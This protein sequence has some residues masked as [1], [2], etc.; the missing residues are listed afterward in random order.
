MTA[1]PALLRNLDAN[2]GTLLDASRAGSLPV[3]RARL[4]P[5]FRGFLRQAAKGKAPAALT[6]SYDVRVDWTYE[7]GRP[8]LAKLYEQA[9]PSQWDT[10]AFHAE[11]DRLWSR[12]S[13]PP[14]QNSGAAG[15]HA[16]GTCPR[17]SGG[18]E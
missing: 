15:T 3:I 10:G 4:G 16:G 5:A 11:F 8:D 2:R 6:S 13:V 17:R 9:K 18:L 14:A 7:R 1:I 12:A